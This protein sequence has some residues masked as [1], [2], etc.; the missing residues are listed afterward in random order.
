LLKYNAMRSFVCTFLAL[1]M[2]ATAPMP[3]FA[4]PHVIARLGSAPLVPAIASTEQLQSD[5]VR[6]RPLYLQAAAKI[7][8]TSSEYAQFALRV[9]ARRITYGTIPRHLD[10]M[11]G[12][13]GSTVSVLHD[14]IVPK[15]TRGWEVDLTEAHQIV[16]IVV[17]AACG[18]I[19]VL[20]KPISSLAHV[21][22]YPARRVAKKAAPMRAIAIVP[23]AVIPP[24]A[25]TPAPSPTPG[26]LATL[27]AS[28]GT[29]HRFGWW[30][31]FIVP[32][33]AAFVTHG[34]GGAHIGNVGI[35]EI[36]VVGPPSAI[37]MPRPGPGGLSVPLSGDTPPAGCATP[38][39][40]PH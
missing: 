35:P 40:K 33:V 27:A 23:R 14:V 20:R 13:S 24:P 16:A 17:P 32:I 6:Y 29:K 5:I 18:N 12:M 9:R 31:A 30:P 4:S 28:T 2:G 26:R 22:R 36:P 15:N 8:L 3:A 11:T 1:L 25:A 39:P 19:S 10:A 38:T 21:R 34:T 37:A 7:G